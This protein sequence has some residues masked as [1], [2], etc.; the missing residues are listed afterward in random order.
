M[1]IAY[2]AKNILISYTGRPRPGTGNKQ[3]QNQQK[4]SPVK[5][6]QL[7]N[8]NLVWSVKVTNLGGAC[9]FERLRICGIYSMAGFIVRKYRGD[10][11]SPRTP[12][13][14]AFG[15]THGYERAYA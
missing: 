15:D 9:C 4:Q 8:K 3:L 6:S 2:R 5:V 12:P 14:T 10:S 11:R 7:N 13:V 1:T